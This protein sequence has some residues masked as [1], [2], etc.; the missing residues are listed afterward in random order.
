MTLD[1]VRQLQQKKFRDAAGCFVV[2]GEHLILELQKAL[3]RQPALA[4]ARLLDSAIGRN[5][6]VIGQRA[7]LEAVSL[8]TQERWQ[9]LGLVRLVAEHPELE[10]WLQQLLLHFSHHILA[11]DQHCA[12]VWGR[13]RVPNP[14][15]VIDKQIAATALVYNLTVV[16]RNTR[17]FDGTGVRVLNPFV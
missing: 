8:Q 7:A 5:F 12:Q 9:D 17:D 2:E 11:F 3:T 6:A 13:L 1:E 14:D 16:T 4:D 15:A 10:Q